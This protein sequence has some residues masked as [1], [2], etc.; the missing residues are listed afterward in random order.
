VRSQ[1]ASGVGPACIFSASRLALS[2][3]AAVAPKVSTKCLWRVLAFAVLQASLFGLGDAASADEWDPGPP[4][5]YV[6]A[7]QSARPDPAIPPG[8]EGAIY[9]PF[10]SWEPTK[11]NGVSKAP[12]SVKEPDTGEDW[13][14]LLGILAIVGAWLVRRLLKRA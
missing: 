11:L 4:Q 14:G 5:P 3:C 7:A 6:G 8:A 10:S 1:S 13:I 2:A 9:N 12:A